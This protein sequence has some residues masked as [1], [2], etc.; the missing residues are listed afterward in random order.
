M[1]EERNRQEADEEPDEPL[2]LAEKLIAGE[3]FDEAQAVLDGI[4]E[5]TARWHYVQSRLFVGKKWYNEARKQLEL[6]MEKDAGNEEYIAAYD[7]LNGWSGGGEMKTVGEQK[8]KWSSRDCADCCMF[9]SCEFCAE[10]VCG[11]ICEGCCN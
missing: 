10:G 7:E 9:A 5:H 4:T 2:A 3:N 1:E 8:G 11:L 6:A